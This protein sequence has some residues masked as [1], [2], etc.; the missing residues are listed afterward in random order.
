M[1]LDKKVVQQSWDYFSVPLNQEQPCFIT[2]SLLPSFSF[3]FWGTYFIT[4]TWMITSKYEVAKVK[5][6]SY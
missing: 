3:Y 5:I 6:M 4:N 1:P 2:P